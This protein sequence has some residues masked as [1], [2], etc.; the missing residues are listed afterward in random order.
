MSPCNL[1][2]L[3]APAFFEVS[4]GT[5]LETLQKLSCTES[6]IQL[7]PTN[8]HSR[9]REGEGQRPCPEGLQLAA[10][11]V[12]VLAHKVQGVAALRNAN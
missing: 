9:D 4:F 8:T 1:D 3:Q 11:A 10:E 5:V 6:L 2:K 7:L 12:G